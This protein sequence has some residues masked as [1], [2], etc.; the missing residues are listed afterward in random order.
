MKF[1]NL[2]VKR[3]IP[4]SLRNVILYLSMELAVPIRKILGKAYSNSFIRLR[5]INY[6]IENL[7]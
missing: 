3:L 1:R 6:L 5:D 2:F 7:N 4:F